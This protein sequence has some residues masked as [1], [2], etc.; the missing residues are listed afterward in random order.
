MSYDIY[1]STGD[2]LQFHREGDILNSIKYDNFNRKVAQFENAGNSENQIG[3]ECGYIGFES[4]VQNGAFE[5]NDY[6]NIAN[7]SL[8]NSE[9][10]SGYYS[11]YLPPSASFYGAERE[12]IPSIQNKKFEERKSATAVKIAKYI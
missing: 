9:A 2:I 10:H 11:Q 8:S 6:W 5:C 3:N 1:N 7:N 4:G 12:F